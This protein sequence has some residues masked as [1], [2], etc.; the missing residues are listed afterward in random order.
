MSA[1]SRSCCSV[2]LPANIVRTSRPARAPRHSLTVTRAVL[3]SSSEKPTK[4]S[5]RPAALSIA[6]GAAAVTLGAAAAATAAAVTQ[7]PEVVETVEKEL[8]Q[9]F[10]VDFG[11]FQVDHKDLIYGVFIGQ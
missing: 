5:E 9:S 6:L 1:I 3:P 8:T 11:G 10:S 7:G 4:R 2:A